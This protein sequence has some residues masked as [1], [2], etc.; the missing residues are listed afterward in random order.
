MCSVLSP[1]ALLFAV[2][3][4]PHRG[5]G[6]GNGAAIAPPPAAVP[7]PG[8]RLVRA[9]PVI[10][11]ALLALAAAALTPAPARADQRT[12][13]GRFIGDRFWTT[14][15]NWAEGIAPVPGD[16]LVFPPDAIHLVTDNDFPDGTTFNSIMITGS[17]YTLNTLNGNRIAIAGGQAITASY[18]TGSSTINLP[19]FFGNG[20]RISV[21]NAA[22]TLMFDGTLTNIA[23]TAG[24]F[25]EGAGTAV[26][27][28]PSNAALGWRIN[29]GILNVRN[30]SALFARVQSPGTLQVQGGFAVPYGISLDGGTGAANATGLVESVSGDNA[31]SGSFYN[32][33]ADSTISADAGASLTVSPSGGNAVQ[34]GAFRLTANIASTA[35][36]ASPIQGTGGLTKT[37]TGLLTLAGTNSYSGPTSVAAGTLRVNGSQPSSSVTVASGA[38]LEGTGTTGP[39]TVNGI[40]SPGVGGPGILQT[41]TVAFNGGS[42]FAVDLNG[43]AAG[44][45]YDELLA[46]G[47]VT[48]AAPTLAV[49]VGFPSAPGNTFVIMQSTGALIGAFAGLPDGATFATGGRTFQINYTANAVTLTDVGTGATSTPTPALTVT[50]TS[51]STVTPTVTPTPCILGD[52]NCDGIVDIRDYGIW[53]AN[54]GQTNCGNPADL[55]GNCIVDI[56]DYGIWRANFGHTAGAAA[57]TAT[58]VATPRVGTATPTPTPARAPASG[59]RGSVAGLIRQAAQ[60]L[61]L[62]LPNEIMLQVT[63]V[64]E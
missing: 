8:R 16:D 18:A 10:L 30:G 13:M 42:T 41:G 1:A 27:L 53:R 12:W 64:V 37:G 23:G 24:L 45:G 46:S 62:P 2:G 60:A 35:T 58:P 15:A 17:G 5:R 55:D 47:A 19:V 57:R 31:L 49:S 51:T 36:I 14:A 61:G 32:L 4:R 43:T 29:G 40:V 3:R 7:G 21:T 44:S 39:L 34:L 48:L 25:K 26:L 20:S 52:I 6:A 56:R 50:P 54:F 22:A 63:E 38:T 9:G 59:E 28:A 33:T 11:G